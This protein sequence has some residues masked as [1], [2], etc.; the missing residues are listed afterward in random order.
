M[1]VPLEHETLKHRI[2]GL[3]FIGFRVDA[4]P[5]LW[6]QEQPSDERGTPLGLKGLYGGT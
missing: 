2:I 5:Y 3:G 1:T 6:T 4:L